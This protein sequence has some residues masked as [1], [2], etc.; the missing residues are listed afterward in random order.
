VV[1]WRDRD[2]TW[3]GLAPRTQDTEL[4]VPRRIRWATKDHIHIRILAVELLTTSSCELEIRGYHEEPPLDVVVYGGTGSIGVLATDPLG[5][6]VPSGHLAWYDDKGG[7]VARGDR[8][9]RRTVEGGVV[10]AVPFGRGVT[11]AEGLAILGDTVMTSSERW[12]AGDHQPDHE[13]GDEGGWD[14]AD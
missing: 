13:D 4:D 2:G 9:P 6:Q 10:R 12:P 5:R 7:E 11:K 1:Q 14:R 3:R 8:L